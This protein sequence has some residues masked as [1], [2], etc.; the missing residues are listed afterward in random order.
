MKMKTFITPVLVITLLMSMP[1]L[2]KLTGPILDIPT[3]IHAL[4]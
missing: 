1:N 3:G 4:T 2:A